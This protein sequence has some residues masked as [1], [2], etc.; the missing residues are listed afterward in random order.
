M[1]RLFLLCV[2]SLGLSFF[3]ITRVFSFYSLEIT[4]CLSA[5]AFLASFFVFP[6]V[7][8][9]TSL[10]SFLRFFGFLMERK[11]LHQH[12]VSNVDAGYC[13]MIQ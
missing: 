2:Y 12:S 6:C 7:F 3:F 13:K 11:T 9:G 1:G 4:I 8:W 5:F 10:C